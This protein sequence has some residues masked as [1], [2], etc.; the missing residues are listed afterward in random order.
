M[1]QEKIK[2]YG[3]LAVISG[4]EFAGLEK[5]WV[6]ISPS[7]DLITGG[8]PGG[9]YVRLVGDMKCGK[10]I[11]SLHIAKNAQKLGRQIFYLDI[12]GRLKK[13]DLEGIEG[14][15][16]AEDKFK[17]IRSYRDTKTDTSHILTA[18]E[19]LDLAEYYIHTVP[20]SLLIFDSIS[21]LLTTKERD[22]E[23]DDQHRA[24]GA[25]LM[26]QF[27]KRM[28]NVVPVNDNILVCVQH[29]I[30]NTSGYG[31]AKVASGGRKIEYAGDVVLQATKVEILKDDNN[32]PYG[33]QVTWQTSSTSSNC[34]PNQSITSYIRYGKGIDE[35]A[36]I[37]DIALMLGLVEKAGSWFKM[38]Y[39]EEYIDD[40]DIKKYQTQGKLKLHHRLMQNQDERDI[41]DKIIRSFNT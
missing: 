31:K 25:K 24:P 26:A 10:T 41:L 35:L 20:G 7:L 30:S 29:L 40:F 36:E 34:T 15:N 8:I 1:N 19:F 9:S 3:E 12:E 28:A 17:I 27:L 18:D 4:E 23:V 16:L 38:N 14:L 13:R 11:T 37:L 6:P 33:Q 2:K 22:G 32:L 39:M 21:M 5:Q